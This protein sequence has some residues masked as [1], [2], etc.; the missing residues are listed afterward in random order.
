MNAG[1]FATQSQQISWLPTI[2]IWRLPQVVP[3]SLFE[4]CF[5]KVDIVEALLSN[6]IVAFGKTIILETLTYMVEQCWTVFCEHDEVLRLKSC[7]IRRNV[8]GRIQAATLCAK[9]MAFQ[10]TLMS[11]V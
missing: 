4:T 11:T 10:K 9:H 8:S 2:T 1:F 3:G 6:N 7:L 5:H